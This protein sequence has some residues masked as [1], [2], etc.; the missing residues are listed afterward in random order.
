MPLEIIEQK[1]HATEDPGY[2]QLLLEN[3]LCF[4]LY[5]CSRK[6]IN[7]Y[8]PFLK[9]LGLTYTQ[10]LVFLVLWEDLETTV[11]EICRR[12]MLDNGTITPVI[13]KMEKEGYV[14]RRRSEEDER[15]V[16][17]A[18]TGQGMQLREQA[19]EIP[20]R[21]GGCMA[22]SSEEAGTLYRLL[23]KLLETRTQYED[24]S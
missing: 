23:Y 21:V 18:I 17:V 20:S 10:Y 4:P 15:V 24:E 1:K 3:Q 14:V 5:A 7:R 22:L 12:L 6:V 13:K 8:S 16:R 19:R 2:E 11:G 9:P